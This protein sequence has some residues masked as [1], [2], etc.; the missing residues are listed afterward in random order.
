MRLSL[1]FFTGETILCTEMCGL[2]NVKNCQQKCRYGDMC[3]GQ[4][5]RY[6][7]RR[8]NAKLLEIKSFDN[9]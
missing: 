7:G 5:T 9:L 4:S 8:R 3:V 6:S 1:A 2:I